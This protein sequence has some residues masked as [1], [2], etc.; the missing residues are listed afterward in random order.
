MLPP[1]SPAWGYC[2]KK[3]DV[4]QCKLCDKA[5]NQPRGGTTTNMRNHLRDHHPDVYNDV[6]LPT[7]T[8]KPK[9]AE[10]TIQNLNSFRYDTDETQISDPDISILSE[11]SV[12]ASSSQ[13]NFYNFSW[14]FIWPTT[15]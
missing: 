11:S 8:S 15:G 10:S 6:F 7:L 9:A 3:G 13:V 2:S 1:K 14:F 12:L 4:A 5:Y